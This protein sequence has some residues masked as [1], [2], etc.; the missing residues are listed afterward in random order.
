MISAKKQKQKEEFQIIPESVNT[1]LRVKEEIRTGEATLP[2]WD[3]GPAEELRRLPRQEEWPAHMQVL[4][5][6]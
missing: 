5:I 2:G 1:G 4:T 3:P 6:F